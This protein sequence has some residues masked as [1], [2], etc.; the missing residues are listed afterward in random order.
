MDRDPQR[1]HAPVRAAGAGA[2]RARPAG[3]HLSRVG[4]HPPRLCRSGRA[5]R[6]GPARR[7]CRVGLYRRDAGR[8]RR[9]SRGARAARERRERGHVG[10][11]ARRRALPGLRDHQRHSRRPRARARPARGPGRAAERAGDGGAGPDRHPGTGADHRGR[12]HSPRGAARHGRPGA[13][14]DLQFPAVPAVQPPELKGQLPHA[15]A[16]WG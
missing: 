15:G 12:H 11:P 4:P 10:R 16:G 13:R 9:G 8:S 7:R 1:G 5:L 14:G 6:A 3:R 2:R